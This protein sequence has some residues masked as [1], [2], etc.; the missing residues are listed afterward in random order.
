M[1]IVVKLWFA[2]KR[3]GYGFGM[4]RGYVLP[5]GCDPSDGPGRDRSGYYIGIGVL[6]MPRRD[7]FRDSSGVAVSMKQRVFGTPPF[8]GAYLC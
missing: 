6:E 7:I 2:G 5:P 1:N 3:R 8:P 4:T